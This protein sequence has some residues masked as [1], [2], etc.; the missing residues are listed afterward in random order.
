MGGQVAAPAGDGK[1]PAP[2]AAKPLEG[3][4]HYVVT[5]NGKEHRVTVAAEK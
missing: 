3:S 5:L 4:I 1:A 2:G